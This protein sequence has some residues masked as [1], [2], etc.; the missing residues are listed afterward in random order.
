MDGISQLDVPDNDL[1]VS[2][3]TFQEHCMV[4]VLNHSSTSTYQTSTPILTLEITFSQKC[5]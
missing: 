5:S 1:N 2:S 3:F 4:I